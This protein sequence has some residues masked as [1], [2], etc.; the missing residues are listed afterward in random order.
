MLL[1]PEQAVMVEGVDN[2]LF[3]QLSADTFEKEAS[4][5]RRLGNHIEVTKGLD[6]GTVVVV[7]GE[8]SLKSEFKKE[9]LQAK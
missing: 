8:C 7:S 3:A 4:A 5:G 1:V 9:S 2:Y 6:E